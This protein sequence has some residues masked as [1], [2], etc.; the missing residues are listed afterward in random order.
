[1]N[2]LYFGD[3]ESYRQIA[4]KCITDVSYHGAS[5]FD[6]CYHS[7][8]PIG[9]IY[10]Y[11]LGLFMGLDP[12]E[13][14][15]FYLFM[16]LFWFMCII[17]LLIYI[18]KKEYIFDKNKYLLLPLLFI[19]LFINYGGHLPLTMADLPSFGTF[20]LAAVLFFSYRETKPL[21][22]S[23]IFGLLVAI[24]A[25]FKQNTVALGVFLFFSFEIHSLLKY[26]TKENVKINI[27]K[28]I[29]NG[30]FFS[31]GL[32]L[33]F[34]QVIS[35]YSHDGEFWLYSLDSIAKFI[36]NDQQIELVAYSLPKPSAYLA[37]VDVDISYLQSKIIR[38]YHGFYQL[39]VPIYLGDYR[40]ATQPVLHYDNIQFAKTYIGVIFVFFVYMFGF[41]SARK[42]IASLS[43][44]CLLYS[45]LI[46]LMGHVEVRY[47]AF[48]RVVLCVILIYFIV[49][50]HSYKISLI[51][52]LF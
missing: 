49:K 18:L 21:L 7:I 9:I 8:R 39:I 50:L 1:M 22:G 35:V 12:I 4:E 44:A 40:N 42:E 46:S 5:A 48:P 16:N 47:Y 20:S 31:L 6:A 52:K 41:L 37:T 19:I 2:F 23:F 33:L 17:G 45:I 27:M 13:Y 34:L 14:N 38:I 36:T 28:S 43:L 29:K 11:A 32:A 25:L 24:S 15:Y 3:A 10:Y 30:M 26:Y 51:N